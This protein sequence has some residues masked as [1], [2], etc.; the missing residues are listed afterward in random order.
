MKSLILFTSL[1]FLSIFCYSIEITIAKGENTPD[2]VCNE[3]DY[4]YTATLSDELPENY[5]VI[6]VPDKTLQL[7]KPRSLSNQH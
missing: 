5:V 6:W 1:F 7:A 3:T 2:N 4:G